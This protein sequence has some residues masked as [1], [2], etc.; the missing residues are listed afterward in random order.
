[1]RIVGGKSKG[2]RIDLP[3]GIDAR[4]TTDFTKEGL[5]NILHHSVPALATA[6]GVALLGEPLTPHL[7][8]A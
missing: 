2:R 8:G 1:M 5:F 6:G 3:K 7:L 4:P